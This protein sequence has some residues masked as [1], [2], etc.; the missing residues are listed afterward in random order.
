MK[1]YFITLAVNW[2]IILPSLLLTSGFYLKVFKR[3]RESVSGSNSNGGLSAVKRKLSESLGLI[4]L[5]FLIC[6]LPFSVMLCADEA[7]ERVNGNQGIG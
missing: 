6:Y 2:V 7:M 5:S 1:K 4:S 3:L